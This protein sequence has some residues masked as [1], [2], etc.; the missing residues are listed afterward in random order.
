MD[1]P[2]LSSPGSDSIDFLKPALVLARS[3]FRVLQVK[4]GQKVPKTTAWPEK[5]TTD[6]H[7]IADWWM[8]DPTCNVGVA[9]GDDW[10][11]LD[12]DPKNGGDESLA[13]LEAEFGAL[14]VTKRNTTPSGGEHI[15]LKNPEEF[16]PT[17]A[18]G[19]FKGTG[20]DVRGKGGQ[21]LVPPSVTP[22]GQYVPKTEAPIAAAPDWVIDF[23]RPTL[24]VVEPAAPGAVERGSQEWQR[25]RTYALE[26]ALPAAT[27]EVAEER[28]ERNN[29]LNEQVLALAGIAAHDPSFLSEEEVHTA[30]VRACIENDYLKDDGRTAFEKTFASAWSAGLTKP[31][32]SWPPADL[33]SGVLFDFLP[34]GVSSGLPDVNLT[35][36]KINE[37]VDEVLENLYASNGKNPTLFTLGTETSVVVGQPARTEPL[38]TSLLGYLCEERMNLWRNQPKGGKAVANIPNRIVETMMSIPEKRFPKI[39]RISF[40]PFFSP[41]GELVTTPGYHPESRTYLAPAIGLEVPEVTERPTTSEVEA[42]KSLILDDALVD[43]PFV[44]Q[45]DRA[46]AVA[47]MLL[48][49]V[50]DMIRGATPLHDIEA[51][52]PG[53]G[54]GYLMKV[55]LM[56]GVGGRQTVFGAPS[57]NDEWEKRLMSFLQNSPQALVVDNVNEKITSGF[58]CTSLTEPEVSGRRLG[59]THQ[60]TVP[61]RCVWV[62]TANNP[63]FS[64]E[65]IERAI[66]IRLDPKMERPRDRT[67]FK[68][69]D[70]QR[71]VYDHRGELVHAC[72]TLIQAWVV[73]GAP[74]TGLRYGSF[75]SWAETMGGLLAFHGI[76][77]LLMNKEE[78]RSEADEES[79]A[80]NRLVEVLCDQ[81]A[82]SVSRSP[83]EWS[84]REIAA[85]VIDNGIDIDLPADLGG[86]TLAMGK[87]LAKQRDRWHAGAQFKSRI[88]TGK[89]MW[90]LQVQPRF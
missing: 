32:T 52:S 39:E 61:V 23:I 18:P 88:A 79:A 38:D 9:A 30:M 31:R 72:C 53:S 47:L 73:A 57:T 46:H 35:S 71:W 29:R 28:F 20:I 34:A 11:I 90:S 77:G 21:I 85:I 78:F 26:T 27:A 43:F 83:L 65:V 49:F 50:R 33:S 5:A 37:L 58:L 2:T 16:T 60:M 42:A 13:R 10:F 89:T 25:L 44:E 63:K 86:Q 64:D 62:M 40:T 51:P 3:G 41:T 36:R 75:E 56:P 70:I 12:V 7:V 74:R 66:R 45:A 54:K 69:D 14:P 22:M 6:S 15:F 8:Q 67:G 19:K 80:W 68:H 59:V 84:S 55:C 48:P 1:N 76:E 17:N 87:H 81:Q 82:K 24:R 4:P